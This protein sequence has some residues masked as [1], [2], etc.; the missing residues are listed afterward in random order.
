M[1]GCFVD[2]TSDSR[3][4]RRLKDRLQ[5][6]LRRRERQDRGEGKSP[7]KC[8]DIHSI[9]L[10]IPLPPLQLLESPQQS[11]YSHLLKR[12]A[13]GDSDTPV[14]SLYRLYRYVILRQINL[15]EDEVDYFWSRKWEVASIPDPLDKHAA[16]SAVLACCTFLLAEDFSGRITLDQQDD[17][18]S[19]RDRLEKPP[20][21]ALETESLSQRLF[22]N[23][24]SG[25]SSIDI[26]P[27]SRLFMIKNIHIDLTDLGL[28]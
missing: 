13:E 14:A 15:I 8:S 24:K 4:S 28:G 6:A 10:G 7:P 3:N 20:R 1:P 26:T 16:R 9:E 11:R 5:Q 23:D 19:S 25:K 2:Y 17:A 12:S 22:I 21:W 27:A 18:Q